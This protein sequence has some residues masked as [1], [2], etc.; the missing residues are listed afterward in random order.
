M[1]AQENNGIKKAVAKLQTISSEEAL[2]YQYDMREKA[3]LDFL[4]ARNFDI[5]KGRKEG[6]KA[7]RIEGILENSLAI[8]KKMK[9]LDIE[10]EQIV[11]ATGLEKSQIL[12]L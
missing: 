7:G 4:Q 8:A 1:L 12:G 3:E 6:M 11:K 10:I 5:K 9:D 2:R